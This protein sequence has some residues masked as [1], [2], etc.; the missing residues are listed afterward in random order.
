MPIGPITAAIFCRISGEKSFSSQANKLESKMREFCQP[1]YGLRD[2][3]KNMAESANLAEKPQASV[4]QRD[5]SEH[6]HHQGSSYS[7]IFSQLGIPTAAS[8]YSPKNHHVMR[9]NTSPLS[10]SKEILAVAV[11]VILQ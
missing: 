6:D 3:Q 11:K 7:A 1:D 5:F 2:Q 4:P 10:P 9:P 8:K